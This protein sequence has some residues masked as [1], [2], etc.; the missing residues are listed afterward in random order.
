MTL[1]VHRA[2]VINHNEFDL[3]QIWG[4]YI[5]VWTHSRCSNIGMISFYFGGCDIPG[6]EAK[7]S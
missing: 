5:H 1:Q 3:T 6:A 2:T 4:R 7:C